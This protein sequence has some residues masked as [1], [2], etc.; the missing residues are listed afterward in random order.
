MHVMKSHKTRTGYITISEPYFMLT[1]FYWPKHKC[2]ERMP[3]AMLTR[4]HSSGMRTAR[5]PTIPVL[6]AVTRCQYWYGG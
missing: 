3:H 1:Q 5:L 2:S 4:R 6:V